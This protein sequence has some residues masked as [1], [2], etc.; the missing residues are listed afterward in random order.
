[1]DDCGFPKNIYYYYQ[2]WW[3]EKDVL[4]ISPHW[5]WNGKEGQPIDVWVNSNA[6]KV[7]LK[8]NGKSLGIKDMPRN[9]HLQW[10]VPYTPGKLQAIAYKQGRKFQTTVETTGVPY[11]VVLTADTTWLKADGRDALAVNIHV[12]DLQGRE[13]PNA[14]NLIHFSL[15]GKGAHFIG[16]GNGDPS[17][18]DPEQFAGGDWQRP[19]FNGKCQII[20]ESDK[21]VSTLTLRAKADG[22]QD[23]TFVL[24]TGL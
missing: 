1:M 22:L 16:V 9:G 18:H 7:E 13:V 21:N 15:E 11:R 2:S 14:Q 10:S 6:D 20:L 3:T 8:L 23:G 17:S 4:H 5:N 24:S 19:L 12:V